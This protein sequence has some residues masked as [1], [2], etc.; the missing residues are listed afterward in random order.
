MCVC[1]VYLDILNDP[2]QKLF[3]GCTFK[4]SNG[5][6]CNYP[7]LI[8]Q[9]PSLCPIHADL[10]GSTSLLETRSIVD[11]I[12]AK[13]KP[14]PIPTATAK[15]N[16]EI[17][18]RIAGLGSMIQSKRHMLWRNDLQ[19]TFTLL[20]NNMNVCLLTLFIEDSKKTSKLRVSAPAVQMSGTASGNVDESEAK[21]T[22]ESAL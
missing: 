12:N 10:A 19:A 9:K 14:L 4:S 17:F 7:I 3:K 15:D 6:V 22:N 13:S 5:I 8:N 2:N 21:K 16:K 1:C 11:I 18:M 20:T